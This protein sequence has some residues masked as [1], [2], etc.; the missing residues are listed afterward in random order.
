MNFLL[1]EDEQS[2]TDFLSRG[3]GAEGYDV[4]AVHTGREGLEKGCSQDIDLIILDLTLPDIHGTQVC[5]ELRT[6]GVRTPIL[7]LTALSS[8]EDKIRGLRMGADD[9]L[10]KP[11]DFEELL[12]RIEALIRRSRKAPPKSS[13][14]TVGDL[15][16]DRETLKVSRAGRDIQLTAKELVLLELLMSKAG[17]VCT[18][19]EILDTVWE[20]DTDPLAN[21]VDVYIRHLRA[22]IDDDR[23]TSLITTVRGT[24]YKLSTD[25]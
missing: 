9:Y 12:A 14:L 25:G 19:N 5:R 10:T 2:F 4:A 1:V 3:L 21:I 22:K 17:K 20:R 24:G 15:C 18:R 11:F 8:I 23:E 13:R 7:I 6:A 16:F